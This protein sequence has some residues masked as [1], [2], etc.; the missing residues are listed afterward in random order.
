[1]VLIFAV[2]PCN[3]EIHENL[4]PSNFTN[5]TVYLSHPKMNSFN[6]KSE[7]RR[8]PIHTIQLEF[9]A[10]I[11][12][13]EI[14]ISKSS[15]SLY[16]LCIIFEGVLK[17][18]LSINKEEIAESSAI[19]SLLMLKNCFSTPSKIIHKTYSEREDLLIQISTF[20]IVATNSN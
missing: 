2:L 7:L 18:F 19:S 4:N 13:V 15:L 11:Q 8:S 5:Y 16:V 3:R 20:W 17:Q 10:T 12:N 6:G 14:C 9:V 1:M